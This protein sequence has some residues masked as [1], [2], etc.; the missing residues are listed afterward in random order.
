VVGCIESFVFIIFGNSRVSLN[1][2][3]TWEVVS[4]DRCC[5]W[6]LVFRGGASSSSFQG[7]FSSPLLLWILVIEWWTW[8]G[9]E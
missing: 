5:L 8:G 7:C 4:F 1:L 2:T 6:W 9:E 3:R